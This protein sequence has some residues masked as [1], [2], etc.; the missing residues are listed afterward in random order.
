MDSANTCSRR[1]FWQK[2]EGK[3]GLCLL[4]TLTR[5][6]VQPAKASG[7]KE[8][9]RRKTMKVLVIGLGGVTNGGKTTLAEKL[10]K[11]L[12]NCDTISQDDFF[13]PESEVETDERGFK[14]Y[15][16]LDALYMDEMVK[17]IRN[18]M[19]NPASSGVATEEP[20]NTCGNL[21]N[22]D[23]VYILIVEGFLLYNY[24]PLNE[25]WNRRFFLTLPYEECKRRRSTRVYQPADTPGYFD[26]HV[27][28]M[29][30]KYKNELEEN[31]S[32]VVY[33]DGTKSQEE[34][35]SCVYSDI[36]KELK[37]LREGTDACT[38]NTDLKNGPLA[39]GGGHETELRLPQAG[40]GFRAA[41]TR[42]PRPA[43]APRPRSPQRRAHPPPP[44]AR[45]RPPPPLFSRCSPRARPRKRATERARPLAAA[46]AG[47]SATCAVSR[48]AQPP[49]PPLPPRPPGERDPPA[50]AMR[51]GLRRGHEEEREQLPWPGESAGGGAGQPEAEQAASLSD[52]RRR[53]QPQE[54][55]ALAASATAAGA[56]AEEER[57]EREHFRRIINAF[58]YYGTNMHERVN[59]T[60]RQFKSLPANQQSLLPQFLPHLDKI[61]KCIDHNQEILQTIVNDCVHMF[62]NK[63]YGEDG[64][65]K[66]TPAST[67][68][69]D[70]LKSTLK[71]FVRD[72]SEEGKPERDSCYQPI[73]SEIVKNFP[74][75]RWDF[76]KVNILVPGA[77]LGRLAWEIAML[78]YACQGNEW[79][80]FM[81]F[82]SNFVL[83][84]CS[85][86]NSCKLYPWIHQFSNNRRSADQIRPIYFPDV[87]PHSLPSGSNFSMTAGDFQEIYSE[88]N[89]W[90]CIATCFFIDTAHNVI[91]YIDTIW[92][93][94]KPGGIWINVGPL[95]Y[96]FENLGNELSIELSYEDIKNVILQYGFH[97]EVEKE[98]VL[99]T[100]TVNELSMMKYYY[101]C[102]LFV[103]RKPE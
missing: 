69:M 7:E 31:A 13:K 27:W 3:T 9:L 53:R 94:L 61:R 28:P 82:S 42:T 45:L 12:P 20:Q 22:T 25:L 52:E 64:R 4:A 91:D 11:M 18:W 83:N 29:Y 21:K 101:E 30:L 86:I 46:V 32:N 88:C 79:S 48:K 99:S 84:R 97:M 60:E 8:E 96:H 72:W 102:V 103:V 67:F 33:L 14:L 44:G 16:V 90:D 34:L 23:D 51:R 100:Y 49:P 56:A 40:G 63:E 10:K 71:Q 17:S 26:G 41:A 50:K 98:S 89:T 74:K 38:G 92:K 5:E 36:I 15:D 87:D 78:G 95:L 6:G 35:L 77:G 2:S 54:P 80:L 65:G 75:E 81:L 85:E 24:E 73:I 39:G 57:L 70:K 76:S 55:R 59:R 19:K 93:I 68:D 37:K 66:I 1:K 58:R 47:M 43:A 62:E